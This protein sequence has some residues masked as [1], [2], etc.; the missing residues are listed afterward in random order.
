[1]SETTPK[2]LSRREKRKEQT[3]QRLLESAER[4]FRTQGFDATTVEEIAE[5]ADV[6]KGTFFNYF[7]SKDSLLGDILQQRICPLLLSPPGEGLPPTARIEALL[8]ALWDELFP[9]RQIAR[10][11]LA[12]TLSHPH[13]QPP[14]GQTL[15]ARTLAGLI[16]EGQAQGIFRADINIETA[17]ILIISF[18]FRLFMLECNDETAGVL[19]PEALIKENLA[20]IYYGM[21]GNPRQG[22]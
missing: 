4:L 21:T 20:L 12:H 18:F 5:A 7:A 22:E 9:Y 6:A 14:P 16:R 19:C 2:T 3:R 15:P 11:M 8:K 17:G 13:H 1:M 10:R